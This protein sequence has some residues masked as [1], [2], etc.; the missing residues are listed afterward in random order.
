LDD[1][2]AAFNKAKAKDEAT[3]KVLTTIIL[4]FLLSM[5]LSGIFLSLWLLT[6]VINNII[7]WF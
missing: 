6:E 7:G 4:V 1:L 5:P 3:H 2:I